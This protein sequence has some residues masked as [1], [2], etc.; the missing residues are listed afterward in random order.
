MSVVSSFGENWPCYIGSTLTYIPTYSPIFPLIPRWLRSPSALLYD[1]ALRRT[2]HNLMKKLFMQLVAEFKR[3]G[4]TVVHANFNR[5][6]L[7][8]KKRRL[9]DALA[10][11]EY[12][13]NAIRSRELFHMIDISYSQCWL[14][15]IWMD[16]VSEI[17]S[18]PPG[19]NGRHSGRRHLQMHFPEWKWYS[20][21]NFSEIFFTG[22]QLTVSHIGSGNGLAPNKRQAITWTN[23][24]PVPWPG[25]RN[26]CQASNISHTKSQALNVPSLVFAQT[27]EA[28][29]SV[30][31]ED[32][33]GTAPT[34]DAPTT[35]EWSA[36]VLPT[37]MRLMLEVWR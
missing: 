1:P 22:V 32:V 14:F 29:F 4:S 31:N 13:T 27:L 34:V 36:I 28:R 24:A 7:S 8:T 11:V 16:P 21:S 37:K 33:V 9:L 12:I 15:L 35:S 25:K 10:Y 17:N 23:A 2:L 3:L 6:I 5:L 30:K 19:Q 20:D 26:Y 18:S